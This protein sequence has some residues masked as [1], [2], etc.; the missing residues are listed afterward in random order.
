M[1]TA[2]LLHLHQLLARTRIEFERRDIAD[3]S[4]FET[5]DSL[6]VDPVAAYATKDEHRAAVLALA[7]A[8]AT[9]ADSVRSA[10]DRHQASSSR[11]RGTAHGESNG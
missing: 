7:A 4:A 2:E 11:S 5:Y 10:Q 6:D 9:C 3:E 1:R 8:L